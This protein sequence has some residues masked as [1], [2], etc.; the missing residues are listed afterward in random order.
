[1]RILYLSQ[2]LPYPPDAGPKVRSYHVLQY[3]AGRHEITLVAFSRPAD[4][5]EYIEHLRSLCR[6]VHTLPMPR[7]PSH[8]ARH[9]L[10]ALFSGQPFLIARDHVPAMIQLLRRLVQEA[11]AAGRPFDAVHA[12]Q[13]WMVPYALAAAAAVR[14][15][16]RPRLVLDQHNAVFLIPRRLTQHEKNPLRKLLLQREERFMRAFEVTACRQFD[17]VVW[18]TAQDRA[19]VE[20]AAAPD[21]LPPST[22][23][24]ICVDVQVKRP[25]ARHPGAHRV[26]FLGGLHWPPNAAGLQW[27]FRRVWPEVHR[28]VPDAVLTVIGRDPPPELAAAPREHLDITGYVDDPTPYLRDTAAFIVPL[29]AGGGMRVKIVDAWAWGVPVVSTTIGAEGLAYR[30]GEN[31]LIEDSETGFAAAVVRLL[32]DVELQRRLA[33]AGRQTAEQHYDWHTVYPAW[34]QVYA[35]HEEQA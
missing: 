17:H 34:D 4:R 14:P 13:L 15:S 31:L 3:L 25:I 32:Q 6:S 35:T 10:R 7:S 20:Q 24:P 27:F 12:D 2:V 28:E 5:R 23:I 22:V 18:V 1:M 11:A 9:L 16:T 30:A 21:T 19:A 33:A 26:T 8:N 29:H